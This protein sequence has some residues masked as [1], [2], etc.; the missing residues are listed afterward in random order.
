MSIRTG[1]GDEMK[2]YIERLVPTL[3]VSSV[4]IVLLSLMPMLMRSGQG[5]NSEVSVFRTTQDNRVLT[6]EEIVKYFS[7]YPLRC[8]LRHIEWKNGILYLQIQKLSNEEELYKD[9]YLVL[10]ECF[11]ERSNV[12]GVRFSIYSNR[13]EG[14][15]LNA[16]REAVSSD[17]QMDGRDA[18]MSYKEYLHQ[19]FKLQCDAL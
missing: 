11:V 6:K 19:L 17:P 3:I 18:S 7:N 2:T 5:S 12:Q 8:E 16:K 13:E 9:I 15:F 4:L 1:R 10:K 14:I